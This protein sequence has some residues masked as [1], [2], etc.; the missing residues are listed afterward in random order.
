MQLGNDSEWWQKYIDDE[1]RHGGEG[2]SGRGEVWSVFRKWWQ[3]GSLSETKRQGTN[4]LNS[5]NDSWNKPVKKTYEEQTKKQKLL[6]I[7]PR[8]A[9]V[10]KLCKLRMPTATRVLAPPTSATQ[11]SWV[12]SNTTHWCDWQPKNRVRTRTKPWG[13]VLGLLRVCE[14]SMV[15]ARKRK[16]RAARTVFDEVRHA[17]FTGQRVEV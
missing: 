3:H 10:R 8:Q 13:V 5:G 4:K 16:V 2:N 12:G 9:V 7:W 14:V 11:G 1:C 15:M 17:E 6:M